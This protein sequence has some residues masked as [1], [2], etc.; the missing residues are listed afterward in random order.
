MECKSSMLHWNSCSQYWSVSFVG[1]QGLRQHDAIFD[2]LLLVVYTPLGLYIYR[3]SL[4]FGLSS[5][6]KAIETGGHKVCIY[7]P[8]KE[9]NWRVAL[10]AI[11]SKLDANCERVALVSW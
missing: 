5:T 11:L 6:G 7:G 2:E 9:K 3:H 4:E 8:S 1:I 10:Q